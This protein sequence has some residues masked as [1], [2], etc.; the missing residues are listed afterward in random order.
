[1]LRDERTGLPIKQAPAHERMHE[2][3]TQYDRAV[4]WA[5]VEL[6]KSNQISIG[7][8]LWEL[9]RD[10]TLRIAVISNTKD[11][12]TKITRQI[13]QYIEKSEA[14]HEVFPGL[15]PTHDPSLPWRGLALTV[16]RGHMGG[17]DPSI[18]AAGVHG[19]IIGSRVDLLILDDI[20]DHENTRTPVPRAD[21]FNWIKSS[22]FSRL[23][24]NARVIV[25]GNSWHP[26]D[27]M[28]ELEKEPGFVGFRFPVIDAEGR[29]TWPARWPRARIE[30]MRGDLGPLEYAR[31]LLCQARDE[32]AARFKR[33]WM[34]TCLDKGEG[35]TFYN[36][37]EAFLRSHEA[38]DAKGNLRPVRFYTGV[39]LAVQ[40]KATSALTVFFTIAVY[41]T[42]TLRD[43]R[44]VLNIESGR[45]SGPESVARVEDHHKRYGSIQVIENNAGQ[46]FLV[47]FAKGT[48]N[49]TIRPF[50]TGR[51]KA[52]PEFGV[53]SLAAEFAAG[54]W[55]IPNQTGKL[56]VEVSQW[57]QDL[58]LYEPP[59]THTGD[60]LMA[61]LV[62]GSRV[63]T[64][65]GLVPIEN[66]IVGDHVLTHK[67]RWRK[68]TGLSQRAYSGEVVCMKPAGLMPLTVTPEH[69]I[70][71]CGAKHIRD[72]TNRLVPDGKWDFVE[73]SAVRCGRKTAGDYLFMPV[74]KPVDFPVQAS[75]TIDLAVYVNREDRKKQAG[76]WTVT[77]DRLIWRDQN[78]P[79][80]LHIDKRAAKLI[81]LYIAEGSTGTHQ[82]T[83]SLNKTEDHLVRFIQFQ[84]K[85]LFGAESS[86]YPCTQG[87]GINVLAHSVVACRFFKMFGSR[88]NKQLPDEWMS[89]SADLREQIVRGWYMG[90]G[91]VPDYT[92][93]KTTELSG[94]SIARQWLAQAHMT[95]LER[96]Y[97]AN[98]A[99]FG[100]SGFFRGV[101]C[102]HKPAFKLKLTGTDTARYMIGASH[103]ERDHWGTTEAAV[104]R[105][106][107]NS[108]MLIVD[109]GM[110][111]R[112]TAY[113]KDPYSGLVYN[114]HV[115]EDESFVAEGIAVHNCW[116]AREG[117]RMTEQRSGVVGEQGAGW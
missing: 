56:N 1:M 30:K 42:D 106:R 17:K 31:Q 2:I 54:K 104:L 107:T 24:H 10:P 57:L 88:D 90:D 12:A 95:L 64:T 58:H 19:N 91:T 99:A 46:E 25:V 94:V 50:T 68:V 84:I 75:T 62:P 83:F 60:H 13:G 103:V 61:C 6:G 96:G 23:T 21:V 32:E 109:G 52:N 80:W 59:P 34:K 45:W 49:A 65:R 67:S 71:I 77:A 20:L 35:L 29:I 47:Q 76:E 69:P 39:D 100:Q 63:S 41:D 112:L 55:V 87:N 70:W 85:R 16:E 44:R 93:K 11:L 79:R 97:L 82:A 18:Q 72:G 113:S 74:P 4:L 40:E 14:L 81:G 15:V 101:P 53:E 22:L 108:R 36:T 33:E 78:I 98:L 114:L 38:R 27:P 102:T 5:H 73:A 43:V 105:E 66:V 115:E 48:T 111:T 110:S 9:G 26:K 8:S 51:N 7:R 28:H 86:V 3:V 117:A 116:F 37:A 89:W 92:C